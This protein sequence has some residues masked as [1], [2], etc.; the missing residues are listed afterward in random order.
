MPHTQQGHRTQ[1]QLGGADPVGGGKPYLLQDQVDDA[2]AAEQKAPQYS[3]GDAAAQNGGQVVDGTQDADALELLIQDH[4]H[5]Q[6]KDQL[7]RY[8]NK[9]V[10]KGGDHRGNGQA[11]GGK[12][13]DIV[14]QAHPFGRVGDGKIR[15]GII[16]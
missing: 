15:K 11:I 16:Q 2:V 3:N 8:G 9:N 4:G 14:L 5:Q 13:L 7:G 1:G 6:C 12:Q 10:F